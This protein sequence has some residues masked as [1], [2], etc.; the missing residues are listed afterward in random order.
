MTGLS[1]RVRGNQARRDLRRE[2]ER[3]IPACA[4]E[5]VCYQYTATAN[6]VYP[7]VCGGTS[8]LCA[9]RAAPPG[10]SPR[11]R[12][13]PQPVRGWM[14]PTGSIPAC[15]GEPLYPGLHSEQVGV[16]PRVCGGTS[17]AAAVD[18]GARGLSPRVRGNHEARSKL[19][20]GARSIPACAGEPA[21]GTTPPVPAQGLS[22]RVRGNPRR[23]HPSH[24]PARSIPACAGEPEN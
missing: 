16:Y 15:A 13:N 18:W 7:R 22:P 11:V 20:V 6:G 2:V 24:A 3:S 1:P 17:A 9:T 4:G 23:R 19:V 12:G 5:P 21:C 10:L 14:L 8:A